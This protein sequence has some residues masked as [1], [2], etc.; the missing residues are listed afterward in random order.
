MTGTVARR[1][2]DILVESSRNLGRLEC[3]KWS[4]Y[5]GL[6]RCASQLLQLSALQCRIPQA[7]TRKVGLKVEQH[8]VATFVRHFGSTT[9]RLPAS[10]HGSPSL[11]FLREARLRAVPISVHRH[12]LRVHTCLQP[13]RNLFLVVFRSCRAR[14]T[15]KPRLNISP[16]SSKVK[17]YS[18]ELEQDD[19]T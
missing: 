18:S 3:G 15:Q 16:M 1:A 17:S 8:R 4:G 11:T 6:L 7:K 9:L 10:T 19:K 14:R 2:Q 13:L 12:R 5:G